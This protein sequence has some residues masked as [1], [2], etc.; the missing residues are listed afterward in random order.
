LEDGEEEGGGGDEGWRT[1]KVGERGGGVRG[2][3]GVGEGLQN[4]LQAT[5]AKEDLN[6]YRWST[7]GFATVAVSPGRS[8][9][10]SRQYR[11]CR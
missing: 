2:V 11:G 6:K 10:V 1:I 4:M 9:S 8:P 7:S 5:M 3:G